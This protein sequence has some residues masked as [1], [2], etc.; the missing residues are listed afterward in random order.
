MRVDD[1]ASNGPSRYCSPR[2]RMPLNSRKRGFEMRVEDVAGNIWRALREFAPLPAGV[3]V[4]QLGDV[5]VAV[6]RHLAAGALRIRTRTKIGA[7][8]TFSVTAH[9]DAR[10]RFV[11]STSDECLISMTPLPC[12]CT[13]S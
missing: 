3:E 9:S 12:T 5:P 2:R 1:V 6:P 11:D 13:G 8:L 4:T 10:T 7:W